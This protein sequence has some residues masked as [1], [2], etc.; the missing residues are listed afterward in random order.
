MVATKTHA[1]LHLQAYLC[2]NLV[3]LCNELIIL[4]CLPI[5]NH[6]ILPCAHLAATNNMKIRIGFGVCLNTIATISAAVLEGTTEANSF[7]YRLV[8][9]LLPIVLVSV[10]EML[11]VVTGM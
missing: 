4:F 3:S 6:I 11:V 1:N 8:W 9:L 10:A 2:P 5:V 7:E